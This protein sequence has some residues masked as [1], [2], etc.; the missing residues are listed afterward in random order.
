MTEQDRPRLLIED[1]FPVAEL[2]IESVRESSPIPGQFPKLKTLHVW[3]ARRPLVASAGAVLASLLPAWSSQLATEFHDHDE[4]ATP[5]AY[6]EWFL[7]LCGIWGDPV[8]ARR[9]LDA[10]NAAGVKLKGNGYGYKQAYKNSPDAQNLSLLHK[11][12]EHAWGQ[13]PTVCD[14][15]A[16]GGSIPY[17]AVRYRL[18]THAN[19]L[20]PVAASVLRSGV[21]MSARY[22]FDIAADLQQ[23]GGEFV[24]RLTNH[25]LPYFEGPDTQERVVAYIFA[26]AVDCPRTGKIVPLVSDWSLRRGDKPVAVRLLTRRNGNELDA[27]EFEIVEGRSIDFDPK[28]EATWSQGKAVSPWDHLTIDSKYI[29]AEAQAGRMNEV[30]YAI[31]IRTASGRGFRAPKPVDL[32]ALTAA[33]A[34]LEQLLPQWEHADVIPA[35]Y[36]PEGNDNRP[37]SYGMPRWRDFFTPRQLLV[38]GCFVDE[39]RKLVPEVRAAIDGP[40]RADAVL[41]LL[42]TMQGKALNWNAQ[43]ASWDVSRQKIRSVFDSHSFAFKNTFAEFEGGT[44]LYAW[45]LDQL[46]DAYDGIAGLLYP[47]HASDKLLSYELPEPHV[48]VTHENAGHLAS[49]VDGSQTL[50]CI[51]PPYY[52]NVMYAELSDFFYVWEKRTLGVL[53]PDLFAEPLTN[54]HDE[55]VTNK[56]RFSHAGRRAQELADHDYTAKMAAIFAECRRV[57]ADDG[58]LTVMFTHK[59]ADAWDSLGTA[60]ITS[61]FTIETSWPVHT[62][63]E[64]SLHQ[65]R[66]NS[67][68]STVFMV[69]RKR[70]EVDASLDR[71]YLDDIEGDIRRAAGDALE[72]A[73][74]QGLTGVDLLL[75]TYG[76]A[77]S[78]LSARWPV[79]SDEADAEGRSRLLRPE[80]ALAVA[81]TEVTRRQRARLAGSG[82][83]FDPLTDFILMS[84]SMFAAREFPYDEARKL[85]LATGGLEVAEVERAKLITAKSGS[86]TITPPHQRLR[87]DSDSHLPGVN[88][89]RRSFPALIDAV[90]TALYIT[91]QD[92]PAAARRW[93]NERSLTVDAR[94]R[95]CLQALLRAVPR[96][97]SSGKWNV[98]E[99][100]LL[101]RLATTCFPDLDIPPDPLDISEQQL[102]SPDG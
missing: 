2:G 9:L 26:R 32:D 63:P 52:D 35:E 101:D 83:E 12:L 15:T 78:E 81:R 22:G 46:T 60:L 79:Y 4:L 89:E 64:K 6:Q 41:A 50:V 102:F 69:C 34:E 94:F 73:A 20:N 95:D 85:A 29:K 33:E 74:K 38:H 51:D 54:K 45:T 25:L 5:L 28:K 18:T 62:E 37:L 90:H 66:K 91:E 77:L 82:T 76:P 10:A 1:W 57:L 87:R 17:E 8:E 11:V 96:T 13:L 53:W 27:P 23:W 88:R 84:W 75:S 21:E 30:L 56:A 40:G 36:F 14:P 42:A 98:D 39:F 65:A 58:V 80:E 61:G 71:V 47:D 3:W 43:L 93:L 48:I 7:H 92:G 19:D 49:I 31:A 99:A 55:A 72:R 44:E 59:R 68:K 86:V 100:E 24:S 67:A 70:S 97:K 16:G